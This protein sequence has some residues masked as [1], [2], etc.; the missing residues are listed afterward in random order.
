MNL[1]AQETVKVDDPWK[2][3]PTKEEL[4]KDYSRFSVGFHIGSPYFAGDFRSLS[5]G[6]YNFLGGMVGLQGGYQISPL[7]GVR[8]SLHYGVNR[9][10]S[11][12]YEDD[13]LLLPNGNTYY[14]TDI[15]ENSMRYRDLY[16]K[17]RML[18]VGLN[19]ETNLLNL[20]R[21]SDGDRRW[22]PDCGTGH[23]PAAF[24]VDREAQ[25]RRQPLCRRGREKGGP[26][27]GR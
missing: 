3:Y 10:G 12:Y 8:L 2:D 9:A 11:Q 1:A 19:W 13:F 25:K 22:G 5:R 14:N 4:Y 23:L 6:N 7:F 17:V 16:S 20:F 27:T 15:P 18:N 21:R 26:G 24:L